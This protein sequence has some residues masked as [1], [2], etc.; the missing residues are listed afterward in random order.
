VAKINTQAFPL[1][2]EGQYVLKINSTEIKKS[3][4]QGEPTIQVL[5]EME[6]VEAP[7]G[8]E[9]LTDGTS[10]S[11]GHTYDEYFALDAH[12][13]A[14]KQGSKFWDLYEAATGY[15]LDTDDEIDTD[16]I[17]DK[18]VQAKVVVNNPGTRNRTEHGTIGK[19]RRKKGKR[20][21]AADE[22]AADLEAPAEGT[23]AAEATDINEEDFEEIPF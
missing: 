6:V 8:K 12:T 19:P 3:E 14:V 1:L 5:A 9:L 10:D 20:K 13:G 15:K 22:D 23:A 18:L 17:V 16:D 4:Y 2:E 11:V 21:A 7:E